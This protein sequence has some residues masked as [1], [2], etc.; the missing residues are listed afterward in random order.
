TSL[1]PISF[2]KYLIVTGCLISFVA[3]AR[4]ESTSVMISMIIR[5]IAVVSGMSVLV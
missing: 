4:I 3:I 5:F 2:L 1:F